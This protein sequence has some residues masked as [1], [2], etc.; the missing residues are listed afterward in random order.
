MP[1][2]K[3]WLLA[4][5]LAGLPFNAGARVVINEI[6]YNAPDDI[7]HLEYVELHNSGDQPVDLG[8]WAFTKGIKFKFPSGAGIRA[9]GY[10][11]VCRN[12]ESFRQFYDAPIAGVFSQH[13]SRKGERLELSD[14]S[15]KVVDTVKYKDSAPWPKGPDGSSGSL[16]RICPEEDGDSPY[17]WASS[18]LSKDRLKPAGT[19]GRAN[20]CYCPHLPPTISEVKCSPQNPAPG[21]LITVDALVRDSSGVSQVSLLY[22]LAGP[23]FEQPEVSTPMTKRSDGRYTAGIPGQ[24]DGQLIRFR[25]QAVGKSGGKRYYPAE[26][27]PRPALSCYVHAPIP[28]ASIPFC[29]IIHTVS[30]EAKAAHPSTNSLIVAGQERNS[31]GDPGSNS[32]S[33]PTASEKFDPPSRSSTSSRSAFV[34]FDPQNGKL[35]VFDFVQAAPRAGGGQKIHLQKD[36]MLDEMTTVDL[37]FDNERAMLA[38]PM[39][40][41]VYRKAG[42]PAPLSRYV[43]LWLDGKP[44]GYQRLVE[45]PNRGFLRRNQM[46]GDGNLYHLH[47][48]QD[49]VP[50]QHEKKTNARGG[51]DD[52][53]ALLNAL[54]K[55]RGDDLWDVIQ[56][57][58]EVEEVANYFAVCMALSNWDGFANNYFGYH[59]TERTGKWTVYP[60]DQGQTWG[61][62][63][64]MGPNEVFC[65]LPITF[66]MDGAPPPGATTNLSAGPGAGI[67]VPAW[68]RSGGPFSKLLLA[69]PQFRKL[70][71]ARTKEILDT[72]YTEEALLPK[73]DALGERLR[74]EVKLRAELIRA[75]PDRAIQDLEQ[76][77]QTLREHLKKRREFLLAQDEIKS[78]AR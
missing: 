51:Q 22:R 68:W 73:I 2:P 1:T 45:Q 57:N 54:E 72:L 16:E 10:L 69:N 47:G 67:S 46:T 4:L 58:F 8:G 11:V 24:A 42:I 21:Q 32:A 31:V 76:S 65:N 74:P 13:L 62:V 50:A 60:W 43:R 36:A 55:A 19:P 28:S 35:Q 53:V 26:S 52:L 18:P 44:M 61:I 17:N 9:K 38:E 3:L 12:R 64:A 37:L 59:D 29:W 70:F 23:G 77:L 39:A 33:G 75:D 49:G 15:G 7:E 30:S 14:A 41:E 66:G 5:L 48:S 25:I 71:L 6:F 56:K 20:A 63:A 34:Y 27:E 78:A 40:Y